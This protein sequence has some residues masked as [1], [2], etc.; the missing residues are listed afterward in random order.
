MTSEF[1]F[2]ELYDVSLKAT[3]PIEIGNRKIESGEVI[4]F[5]DKITIANMQDITSL[6]AARGGK[7]NVGHVFWE[8]TKEINMTFAQ[9]VFSQTQ[10]AVLFNSKMI[11][12]VEDSITITKREFL[13]SDEQKTLELKENPSSRVFV[14]DKETGEQVTYQRSGKI[15]T[16]NEQYHNYIIDY[17]YLY[18]GNG[19]LVNIGEKL[20]KGYV[21]LEGRTKIKEDITGQ[22]KTGIVK[23]PKLKIVSNISMRLGKDAMPMVGNFRAIAVPTEESHNSVIVELYLLEDDI[24]SDM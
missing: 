24:D 3:Y 10:L 11:E 17:E 5:F 4:A 7:N 9:G 2:K 14:Y 8:T 6:V 15:L 21:S 12:K 16:V 18:S 23:I 13:E 22:V 1:S 20:L 19:M